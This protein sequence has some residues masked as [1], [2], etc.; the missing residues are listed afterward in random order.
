VMGRPCRDSIFALC[1]HEGCLTCGGK[2]PF[3]STLQ[4]GHPREIR[5][6]LRHKQ[7]HS[8]PVLMRI[9]PV[10]DGNGSI[11]GAA[12]SFDEQRFTS[13]SERNQYS[14]AAHGCLDETTEVPNHG[15]LQ[16]QLREGLAAFEEYHLPFGVVCIQVDR[17]KQFCATYGHHAGDAV[18]RVM[19]QTIR[20]GLRPS[21]F[22]G[23]WA[24]DQF[25]AI[26][27]NCGQE[28][29]Q[30]ACERVCKLATYAKLQWWGDQLSITTSIG[31]ASLQVGDSMDSLV[32]RAQPC[33]AAPG[34]DPG[35]AK[36]QGP[37]PK[38]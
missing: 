15:Y 25:L 37:G 16:F 23:R 14:L 9:A 27:P 12:Q 38:S 35:S 5:I 36:P 29:V 8:G 28:G 24:E 13:E 6:Q 26:L 33:G 31:C 32:R 18:L 1:N 20:N 22:L 17:L 34:S 19:A 3:T 4:D 10:F 21:D 2:C 7:G 30:L 11:I